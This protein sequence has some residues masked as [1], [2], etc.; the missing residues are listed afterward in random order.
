MKN[1]RIRA[2]FF[3]LTFFCLVSAFRNFPRV[4]RFFRLFN[5]Q[6]RQI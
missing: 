5:K 1:F 4:P 2:S 3:C 6:F